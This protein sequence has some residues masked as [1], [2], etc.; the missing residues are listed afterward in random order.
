MVPSCCVMP[1]LS[2]TSWFLLRIDGVCTANDIKLISGAS[3]HSNMVYRNL[4]NC[5]KP[6]ALFEHCCYGSNSG[7]EAWNCLECMRH[8]MGQASQRGCR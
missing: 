1:I 5:E 2:V 7:L 4:S 3:A 6:R 8:G